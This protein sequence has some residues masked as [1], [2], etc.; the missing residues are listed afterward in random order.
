[1]SHLKR[2]S[3]P[4]NWPIE[5]K[6]TTFV[7]KPISKKGIPLLIV[8][9]DLLKVAQTRKEVKT[10]IHRKYLLVNNRIAKD[11]KR[12]MSLFDTLSIVPSKKHYLIT[13]S[14]KGDFKLEEISEKDAD[15]KI[16][17]VINKRILKK[18][19]I[20]LNLSDGG[21]IISEIKCKTNDSVLL[22][23]KDKKIEKCLPLKENSNIIVFAGKHSGKRGQIEKINEE[24]KMAII[25]Y[26]KEK[27]NILIKQLMVTE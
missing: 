8:L 7:V 19:K 9:R 15:K 5:R 22:N 14:E 24:K 25:K 11:E 6:G 13:L 21:N 23:L 4:K 3:V 18:K 27:S 17:K 20:Q 2:Q 10:A 12:S 16:V 26:G 1:M